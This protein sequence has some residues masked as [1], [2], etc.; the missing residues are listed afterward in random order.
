MQMDVT[1]LAAVEEVIAAARAQLGEPPSLL[2]NFAG[3]ARGAPCHLMDEETFDS[4]IDV[5]LKVS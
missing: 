2:V 5:N 4:V 3:I 1:Q